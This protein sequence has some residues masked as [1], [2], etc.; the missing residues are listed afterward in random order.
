MEET[1]N[2]LLPFSRGDRLGNTG[3]AG[4]FPSWLTTL[5]GFSVHLCRQEET[6]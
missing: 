5:E 6:A 4:F 1:I 3:L 2:F